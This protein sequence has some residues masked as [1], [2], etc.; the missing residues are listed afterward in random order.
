MDVKKRILSAMTDEDRLL[1]VSC[2]LC[3]SS[4]FCLVHLKS[5]YIDWRSRDDVLRV[6]EDESQEGLRVTDLLPLKVTDNCL[7]CWWQRGSILSFLSSLLVVDCLWSW[8][9]DSK[10]WFWVVWD[11]FKESLTRVSCCD[12]SSEVIK[13]LF[14]DSG[15]DD[16]EFRVNFK[17][18]EL[19]QYLFPV[20]FGPSSKTWPMCD[21]H[22][23][24][25]TSVRAKSG[26]RANKRMFP[27]T[28]QNNEN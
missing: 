28:D 6:T 5:G 15:F 17:A 18:A 12:G 11:E 2:S 10:F 14:F 20:G 23:P 27:P 22:W 4:L 16:S 8:Q 25:V 1:L 24:H 7:S 26:L 3:S 13:G 9:E 19:M 21:P